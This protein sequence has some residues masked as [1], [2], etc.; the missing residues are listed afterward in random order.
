MKIQLDR[1][2]LLGFRMID[3]SKSG[4]QLGAKLGGKV[5]NV[6]D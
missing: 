1:K 4:S 6:K 5:G 2:K 3:A